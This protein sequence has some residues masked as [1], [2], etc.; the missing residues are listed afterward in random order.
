MWVVG[1]TSARAL[2]PPYVERVVCASGKRVLTG[3]SMKGPDTREGHVL[4]VAVIGH[5]DPLPIRSCAALRI[6]YPTYTIPVKTT[7]F[8]DIPAPSNDV[9]HDATITWRS[10][11]LFF[12]LVLLTIVVFYTRTVA[13][14]FYWTHIGCSSM[15]GGR[16]VG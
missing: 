3:A 6:G 1:S 16:S 9:L 4:N 15:K 8:P 11:H 2:P 14:W 5:W 10:A 12:R 13:H 7:S